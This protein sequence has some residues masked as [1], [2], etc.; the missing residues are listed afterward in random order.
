M[1]QMGFSTKWIKAVSAMYY[2]ASSK[3]LIGGGKEKSLWLSQSVRLGCPMAPFLFLFFAE[4]MSAY[5]T[6]GKAGI[7]GLCL[8]NNSGDLV[9]SEFAD[10]TTLYIHGTKEN[11]CRVT[12]ALE[13]FSLGS[14]ARLNWKKTVGFWVSDLAFPDWLPHPQFKWIVEGTSTRYLGCQV[15]INIPPEVQI[16]PLL[17]SMR[18]KLLYWS[19]RRLSLAGRLVV[20]NQ[21]LLS[22]MWYVTSCW[23][24]VKSAIGQIQR[25]IRNFI[26]AGGD[27]GL[28]RSKVAWETL[29]KPKA[30][31]GLGLIDPEKQSKALLVK[32]L[33]RGLLPGNE[34]WK[35]LLKARLQEWS[36]RSRGPWT[37]DSRWHFLHEFK[38]VTSKRW[39]DR[40]FKSLGHAWN[41]IKNAVTYKSVTCKEGL[42]RQPVLWNPT[43][44]LSSGKLL[45]TRT[46]L[47]WGKLEKENG[48]TYED[49]E[50][51]FAQTEIVKDKQLNRHFGGKIMYKEIFDVIQCCG[52]SQVQVNVEGWFGMFSPM[53]VILGVRAVLKEGNILLFNVLED[54]RLEWTTTKDEVLK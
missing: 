7:K 42:L 50:A 2:N 44:K 38:V 54:G 14:G 15:G 6:S 51:F 3:V 41:Q 36:P 18:K 1:E 25:L 16:A 24:Y 20:A 43:F 5:L 30:W 19:N 10:D 28:A 40:F 12:K 52:G 31:G 9:D 32:L 13:K 11:L 23:I 35:I 33:I 8:P 26:W 45:G 34:V 22:S 46:R 49:W 21:V 53:E 29:T 39:E 37:K 48:R 47:G 4:A 17:H 27:D